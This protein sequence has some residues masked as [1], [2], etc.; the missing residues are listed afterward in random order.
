[1]KETKEGRISD[2]IF[3]NEENFYT[4]AVFET[5]TEQFY[6]VGYLPRPQKGRRYTLTGEW[7]VHPRYGE[8]F[9]FSS[10][11][12]PEPATSDGILSFLSSGIV[13]GVGPSTA[14]AIVRTF[15]DEALTVMLEEPDR[16][17]EVPGIG[18]VKAKTI[19]ESYAEHKEYASTVMALSSLDLSA[20]TCMK[21]YK[22][23]GSAAAD[24]VRENPYQ[25][26][27]DVFGIGFRKADKIAESV[28]LD[29]DSPF[30]IKAG[31][32]YYLEAWAGEGNTYAQK[33]WFIEH[34][35][36]LL[37][38]SREQVEEAMVELAFSGRVFSEVLDGEEIL[39]LWRFRRAEQR[40]AGKLYT[41][42]HAPL[43]HVTGDALHLIAA[44]EAETGIR[45]S[46]LQK[47]AVISSLQNGVSVITGGPGTGKTTIIN[48]ILKILKAYGVETAL[49]A[50]TGRAA[51][52]MSEATGEEA[53]T[54]HRLLEYYY[55]DDDEE[56]RFGKTEEDPLHYQC[57]IIDEMSMVD[58]L[59]MEG[60]LAAVKPG[61][62]LILVGDADQLPSVGA[63]NVLRDILTSETVHAVRLKE[64]FRQAAESLIVVNAHRINRGEYPTYNEKDKDFFFLERQ[65]ERDIQDTVR[66]LLTTRLPAY[67][68]D[69]DPQT[70]IQVLTP[71]KKGLLGSVELN[72]LLQSVLNPPGPG[73]NEKTYGERVYREGDKVM[74]NKN[75]YL[76]EWKDLRDFTDGTGVFNGDLGVIRSVDNDMGTVSVVFDGYRLA[77]YDFSNLDEIET[78]FAMT[79]HKSQGSEFPV[80]VMPVARFAPMLATR[81]LLYTAVTRAK[82]GAVLVGIPQAVNAMVDNNAISVRCSALAARLTALWGFA[83]GME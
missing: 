7:K 59:L 32:L 14:A 62:R 21:L 20:V 77:T 16:L 29:K 19:A 52:R 47:D 71:T 45:L 57:I 8:Q 54:I 82:R 34:C 37:D 80:V 58:I 55:S 18:K 41:L 22:A 13:K 73:K 4:I 2:L 10:F 69:C 70:D 44:S 51:K 17:T 23:Y 42:C 3:H 11:E 68:K 75:D 15:G 76:L 39:Q 65:R 49:A 24:I 63:G 9:A 72:R 56:M 74:Q 78:A 38:V 36:S 1:M 53:S 26:I 31:F 67:Y 61:T 33:Q 81:N 46:A 30:R 83:D 28:G 66:E 50:P 48:T 79:V 25:L 35:A 43:T 12:E 27:A 40:V 5:D 64:I 60:L 6:A